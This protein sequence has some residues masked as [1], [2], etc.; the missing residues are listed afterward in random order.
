V[1]DRCQHR[2]SGPTLRPEEKF[3]A[4]R[5]IYRTHEASAEPFAREAV[6]GPGCA[7]CCTH[8]G[9][10]DITTLEGLVIRR[11]LLRFKGRQQSRLAERL[12]KNR[13]EKEN[14]AAAVCPFLDAEHRCRIYDA[15]PFSCRQLYSVKPCGETGP[16]IHRQAVA[17]AK[18]TVRSIQRLDETGYSGHLTYILALLEDRRFRKL[19][20]AGGF[21]PA[22]IEAFGRSHGIVINRRAAPPIKDLERS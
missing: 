8:Y 22:R 2:E 19:Y 14:G 16:T 13:R 15:R 9:P 17:L 5:Q 3:H 12:R 4:L 6:C 20:A 7:Y 18:E 10:L 21:D 1:T 11:R